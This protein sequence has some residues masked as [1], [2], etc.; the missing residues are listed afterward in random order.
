VSSGDSKLRSELLLGLGDAQQWGEQPRE[1]YE[2]FGRAVEITRALDAPEA[3]ARAAFGLESARWASW[4]RPPQTHLPLLEEALAALGERDLALRAHLE[5]RLGYT[6][7]LVDAARAEEVSRVAVET[8]RRCK[9]RDALGYA[10]GA[11]QYALSA[12]SQLK[13]RQCVTG[14]MLRISRDPVVIFLANE[15][16]FLDALRVGDPGAAEDALEAVEEAC[17]LHRVPWRRSLA[18]SYA[19]V[20]AVLQGRFA[21]AEQIALQ[22]SRNG[23]RLKSAPAMAHAEGVLFALRHQQGR[24]AEMLPSNEARHKTP[25]QSRV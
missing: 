9:D 24:L 10:L 18:R 25:F 13:E 23:K 7:S 3:F 8:G 20:L 19:G 5:G 16:R 14:E 4:A 6:L 2:A 21:D 22:E 11:R 12:P 15:W 1:A 17:G